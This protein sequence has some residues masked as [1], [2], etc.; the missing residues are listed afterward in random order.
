MRW[1][2]VQENAG[3]SIDIIVIDKSKEGKTIHKGDWW[4][5]FISYKHTDIY[6]WSA[7]DFMPDFDV[8]ELVKITNYKIFKLIKKGEELAEITPFID[9]ATNKA[10]Q[11]ALGRIS[12]AKIQ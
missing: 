1:R 9:A 8:M 6:D 11:E 7:N 4:I 3:S 2:F 5:P 10:I 12:T